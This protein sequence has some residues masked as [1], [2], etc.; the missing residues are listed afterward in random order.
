LRQA[1][2]TGRINQVVC[3]IFQQ[4]VFG[5]IKMNCE[6]GAEGYNRYNTTLL[7]RK[8]PTLYDWD[9]HRL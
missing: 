7:E 5:P 1:Y 4:V 6:T 8:D 3:F 2:A 9:D